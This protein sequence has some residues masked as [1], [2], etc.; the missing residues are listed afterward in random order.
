[1]II[2][3]VNIIKKYIDSEFIG[4]T[5]GKLKIIDIYVKREHK[6]YEKIA[7]CECTCGNI[8]EKHFYSVIN[9]HTVACGK[10]DSF[11]LLGQTFGKLKVIDTFYKNS[12]LWCKCRCECS[13]IINISA[14]N[15]KRGQIKS[16]KKC[17]SF[18]LKGKTFN[19]LTVLDTFYKRNKSNKISLWCT[20]KCSCGNILEVRAQGLKSGKSKSCGTCN[21]RLLIGKTF[22]ELTILSTFYKLNKS[23]KNDLWCKC[24]CTCGK[25]VDVR[26]R[27]LMRKDS[28]QISCGCIKVSKGQKIIENWLNKYNITYTKEETFNK[29]QELRTNKYN[30]LRFDIYVPSNNLIIEFDG[31]QHFY[32]IEFWGGMEALNK[33]IQH[34]KRKNEWAK[35]HN[36]NLIR[37]NYKESK[38]EIERILESL[39]L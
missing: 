31:I 36:I 37:F 15:L 30:Y 38:Q 34:D 21:E 9:G 11:I 3:K 18:L 2:K 22:G 32:P 4:K 10:C 27:S 39:L 20:C 23:N 6:K 12:K 8:V 16:C 25:N 1:M 29:S 28:P 14:A 17:D 33:T 26:A 24:K 13:N 19:K 7:K 5:F 35:N